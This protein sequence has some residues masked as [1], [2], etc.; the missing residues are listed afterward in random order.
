MPDN[1]NE[2]E[3]RKKFECNRR[4]KEE[5]AGLSAECASEI[6]DIKQHIRR[7]E[8]Q[9]AFEWLDVLQEQINALSSSTIRY[10]DA[11]E[12]LTLERK[13]DE[14]E[15]AEFALFLSQRQGNVR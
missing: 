10:S 13:V 5:Y 6:S 4:L 8:Q 11:L 9:Q 15:Q 14:L 7:G 2:E 3:V 1:N 12:K